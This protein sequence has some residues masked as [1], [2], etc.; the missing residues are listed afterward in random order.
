MKNNPSLE[1]Y[2]KDTLFASSF[3]ENPRLS[4]QNGD[5]HIS[6]ESVIV[7]SK[8][9][10]FT[11]ENYIFNEILLYILMNAMTVAQST[12][13]ILIKILVIDTNLLKYRQFNLI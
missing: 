10:S 12:N 7:E 9:H 1:F 3:R 2:H 13:D 4:P 5:K 8:L 6:I 11:D